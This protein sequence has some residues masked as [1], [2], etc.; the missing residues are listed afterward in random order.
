MDRVEQIQSVLFV[1]VRG[2]KKKKF[3]LV[4][5]YKR[6]ENLDLQI[7]KSQKK[8]GKK[9]KFKLSNCEKKKKEERNAFFNCYKI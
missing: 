3:E 6:E 1:D 5:N 2:K 4:C 9:R 8:R 7:L